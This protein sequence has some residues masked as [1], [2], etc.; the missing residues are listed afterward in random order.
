MTLTPDDGWKEGFLEKILKDPFKTQIGKKEIYLGYE[1]PIFKGQD[2]EEYV[3]L[4]IDKETQDVVHVK[5]CDKRPPYYFFEE[6]AMK[7]DTLF[8]SNPENINFNHYI[9]RNGA[10]NVKNA[11]IFL[12]E[13]LFRPFGRA[14]KDNLWTPKA[15]INVFYG[16]IGM[17]YST[18]FSYMEKRTGTSF[19]IPAAVGITALTATSAI[20]KTTSVGIPKFIDLVQ[21]E[22]YNMSLVAA[23]TTLS[24][25]IT[26]HSLML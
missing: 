17:G 4:W 19:F 25:G 16:L 20:L 26:Y 8:I 6:N 10:I 18:L 14:L 11:A 15:A 21:R 3:V 2:D 23:S 5:D 7:K 24:A 22:G 9:A 12:N 1:I 13:N